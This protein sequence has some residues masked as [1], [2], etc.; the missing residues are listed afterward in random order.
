MRLLRFPMI[1]VLVLAMCPAGWP[2]DTGGFTLADFEKSVT[3]F[4]LANGM[5]FIVV[6][7]HQVPVV[8]FNLYVDVGSVDEVTG[9]T[10]VS[11]LFEHMAFKGTKTIGTR[12][13]SAEKKAMDAADAA[14]AALQTEKEKLTPDPA[15]V[16]ELDAA[17]EKASEAADNVNPEDAKEEFSKILERAG[18]EGL[19]A[20]TSYDNTHY[21]FSLPSN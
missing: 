15:K 17:F 18:A 3:E 7:R 9:I 19:N 16:K 6:E 1:F 21:T 2:A 8:A 10:G 13:Y 4:T 14:Y 20:G 11:H 5:K 12:N